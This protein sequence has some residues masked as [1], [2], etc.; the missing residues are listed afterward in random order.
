MF[1]DFGGVLAE[2]VE[3]AGEGFCGAAAEVGEGVADGGWDGG[4]HVAF[5]Q[6]AAGE[7]PEGLREH[8]L[9]DS[10]NAVAQF[11]EAMLTITEGDEDE[12]P[13]PARELVEHDA[14]VAVTVEGV[15]RRI[16]RGDAGHSLPPSLPRGWAVS[17][18]CVLPHSK[19]LAYRNGMSRT[20]AETAPSI[21]TRDR[22]ISATLTFAVFGYAL[23]Q[24]LVFP[25]LSTIQTD[26]G[27][28]PAVGAWI[29]SG[30]L[31]SSAILTPVLGALGDARGPRRVL[32]AAL[33]L[34]TLGGVA[35]AV[36]PN[37]ILL[38]GARIVQGVSLGI[39]PLSFAIVRRSISAHRQ[40]SVSGLLAG[41]GGAGA[42]VGLVIGGALT[43]W[44]SWRALFGVGAIL[45]ALAFV[46]VLLV[47][48]RD[49]AQPT[50]E[51]R[52][53]FDFLGALVLA[54]GLVTILLGLTQGTSWGW[55]SPGVWALIA[56]GILLLL[57]LGPIE[58][59]K[60]T[61]LVD[62][63][64]LRSPGLVAT[65]LTAL[66]I[67]AI[68]FPFYLI[69][70]L[71]AQAP[72]VQTATGLV[73]FG[74]TITL[75][76]IIL[77]P[78]ALTLLAGSTLTAPVAQRTGPRAPLF[79]GFGLILLATLA[80]T[81]WHTQIWQHVVF[82]ALVGL[83]TG[84]VFASQPRLIAAHVPVTRTGAANGFNNIARSIGSILTTQIIAAIV[85]ATAHDAPITDQ[86]LTVGLL[87][88]AALALAG[89]LLT[90][91][92]TKGAHA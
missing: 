32:L 80:L 15:R 71:W 20:Q 49:A 23:A 64:E 25:A 55:T 2:P 59:R 8:L 79:V 82:Y 44:L 91:L 39:L 54:A 27:A 75:A 67:G 40:Q 36:A 12:E 76:G 57:A 24:T 21:P 72:T 30:F 45:F 52:G 68:S 33:L 31:L 90:P 26:L 87:L 14:S 83:G 3:D 10:A 13:P 65:H 11:E 17:T 43:D 74:G 81:L 61:P 78:G 28:T 1:G 47:V 73:G 38:I 86:T 85:A 41:T 18:K 84:F 60:T 53:R 19:P 7:A 46:A 37:T 22:A 88:T 35:A 29:V 6:A 63:T 16:D 51:P 89:I 70:P 42:G 69:L 62:V 66:L 48:P 77:L 34:A 9:A 4:D 58:R 5:D 92:T 56:V 50:G